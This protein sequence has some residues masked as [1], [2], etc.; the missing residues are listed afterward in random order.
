MDEPTPNQVP[1]TI[2]PTPP[3]KPGS[4]WL[5]IGIIGVGLAITTGVFIWVLLQ[6]SN[7]YVADFTVGTSKH[8][9]TEADIKDWKKFVDKT[10]GFELLV[11]SYMVLSE[12]APRDQKNRLV[13]GESKEEINIALTPDLKDFNAHIT[14]YTDDELKAY[15]YNVG[16]VFYD[17]ATQKWYQTGEVDIGAQVE[18]TKKALIIP[19]ADGITKEGLPVYVDFGYGDAGYNNVHFLVHVPSKK[20]IIDFE[21]SSA[22]EGSP[23]DTEESMQE[24]RAK[25]DHF[26]SDWMN[27]AKSFILTNTVQVKDWKTY[28]NTAYGFSV[29]IP[30]DWTATDE[31]SSV[32]FVSKKLQGEVE[33]NRKNC[34]GIGKNDCNPE[35]PRSDFEFIIALKPGEAIPGTEQTIRINNLTFRRYDP[36]N[37]FGNLYYEIKYAGRYYW[38]TAIT[39][40]PIETILSTL[41]FTN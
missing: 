22:D 26:E 23:E 39:D 20:I 6:N 12:S 35:F 3:A 33:E 15:N 9:R 41:K 8:A 36:G 4:H 38:F 27:V 28:T 31:D 10:Y 16:W 17:A 34:D 11:P 5:W 1:P 18:L 19:K 25:I 7:N 29:S 40:Q 21:Y 14:V 24:S 13:Q 2:S 37:L 32:S 30:A